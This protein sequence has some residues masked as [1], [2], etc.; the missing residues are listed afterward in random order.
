[1]DRSRLTGLLILFALSLGLLQGCSSDSPGQT[2]IALCAPM[3]GNSAQWGEALKDGVNMAVDEIN[4]AGGVLGKKFVVEFADD[5]GDPKEA[6]NVAQKLVT[7]RDLAAVIGHY[8]TS[9]TMAASPVYQ[10]AGIPEIAIASTHPDATKAGEY[11][12]R[13]NVT[14]THQGAGI[15][16]WLIEKG[17]KRIAVIYVNDDYGKGISQIAIETIKELGGDPV[18]VGTVAP[19][20]EQDFT[21]L[22]TN[23][24]NVSPD[25][26]AL[27]TFY[28]A[29]AQIAIQAKTLG[30]DMPIVASDAI[31]SPDFIKIAGP[32]AEGVQVATWFHPDSDDPGTKAFTQAFQARYNKAADTWSPYAYDAVKVLAEAIKRAGKIDRAAIRDQLAQTKSFKGAVGDTTFTSDRVPDA[33]AKRLLMTVVQGGK[34]TLIK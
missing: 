3:T 14:N 23:V 16:K 4:K 22:L 6:V 12:F 20:G 32:S 31:Y 27:F 26:L 9:C 28:A 8:F 30:L 11:I 7:D 5:K 34:F 1:M 24:K 2:K 29:G 21:V 25:A 13:I 33:T 15:A 18:Y 17:K 19:S 10:K